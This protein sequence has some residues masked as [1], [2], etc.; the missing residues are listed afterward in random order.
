MCIRLEHTTGGHNKFYEMQFIHSK[1]RIAVRGYYGAIGQASKEVMIYDGNDEM[2]ALAQ[3]KKKQLE[4]QK[5]GYIVVSQNGNTILSPTVPQKKTDLPAIWPMNAQGVKDDA[6]LQNLLDDDNYVAQEKLDGMRAVIRIT[7]NGLRIFSRSAGVANP[8]QPLEK[9]SALPHLAALTFPDLVGTVLDAEILIAGKDCAE[10]AGAIH[11]KDV[12][13]VGGNNHQVIAYIFD[14]L[15]INGD[16]TT[17]NTLIQRIKLLQTIQTYLASGHIVFLPWAMSTSDKRTLYEKI[18]ASGKEGIMI[19]R[20]DAT[21]IEGGRPSNN[22]IKAKKSRCFDCVILGFS[23]GAGKY[24]TQI[25]AVIFGQYRNGKLIQLGQA[26]GMTDSIRGLMSKYPEQ[27][28][29]R[30]V[31]IKGM[32]RLKSGSIRHPQFVRI[33]TDKRPSDCQWNETEQ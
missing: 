24:N 32:Q 19:K 1:E 14:I 23:K 15:R 5:K 4:K 18:L 11:R 25:G 17:G 22:W 27:Y 33:R 12:S 29:G 7:K 9:T 28:L 31:E 20:L 16:D 2:E 21:Y 8:S 13:D 3:L 30:V 10:I 26:S 6:H